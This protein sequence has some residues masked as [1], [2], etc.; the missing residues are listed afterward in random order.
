MK[1]DR[2][3]LLIA[4]TI[5]L[6]FV[7]GGMFYEVSQL[8]LLATSENSWQRRSDF[9]ASVETGKRELSAPH[10]I[11]IVRYSLDAERRRTDAINAASDLLTLLAGIAGVSLLV[12]AAAI[13]RIPREHWP[14]LGPTRWHRR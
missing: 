9:I 4:P 1:F 3:L 11:K 12:L 2:K 14:S 8:R 10:A 7:V 6:L 13:R 5:V